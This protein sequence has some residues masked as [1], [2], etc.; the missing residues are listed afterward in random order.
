MSTGVPRTVPPVLV[1]D[2]TA[3][4]VHNTILI[5]FQ[6]PDPVGMA[7]LVQ[8]TG[9]TIYGKQV[10]VHY[11]QARA[12][13]EYLTMRYQT[14]HFIVT[15]AADKVLR[16]MGILG[17][18]PPPEPPP[19]GPPPAPPPEPSP[20]PDPEPQHTRKRKRWRRV[21]KEPGPHELSRTDALKRL[22]LRTNAPPEV[23]KAAYTALAKIHHPDRG[24]DVERMK[25]VNEAWAILK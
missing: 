8:S 9:G 14:G 25:A 17:D 21:A 2:G 11:A 1:A 16:D 4:G 22:Y 24:G 5:D 19:P 23:I 15:D 3:A 18:I 20:P 13:L 7:G 10:W 6:R 12:A